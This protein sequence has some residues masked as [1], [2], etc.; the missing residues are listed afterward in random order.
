VRSGKFVHVC[1]FCCKKGGLWS[2]AVCSNGV[3]QWRLWRSVDVMDWWNKTRLAKFK[4][5]NMG[6]ETETYEVVLCMCPLPLLDQP[7]NR[8]LQWYANQWYPHIQFVPIWS[9]LTLVSFE[10][11]KNVC[12]FTWKGWASYI[13]AS[14]HDCRPFIP[15]QRLRTF[16]HLWKLSWIKM[17][18]LPPLLL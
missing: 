2:C 15:L 1:L 5:P 8:C 16:W 4:L 13:G 18:V 10:I 12:M 11:P 6:D 17:D 3:S 9:H 14:L 7:S